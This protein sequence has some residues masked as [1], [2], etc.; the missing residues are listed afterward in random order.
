LLNGG[1]SVIV[2][3]VPEVPPLRI[4]GCASG[5]YPLDEKESSMSKTM[6]T[7][8]TP[9]VTAKATAAAAVTEVR[10]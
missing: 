7:H 2:E 9:P 4:T 5:T 10:F 1:Y 3:A 8:I 6:I